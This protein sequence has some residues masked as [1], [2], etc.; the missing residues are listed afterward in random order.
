[1]EIQSLEVVGDCSL[2]GRGPIMT[3]NI[4]EEMLQDIEGTPLHQA[5]QSEN[6]D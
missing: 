6:D 1:L 2:H 5:L 4:L 3:E